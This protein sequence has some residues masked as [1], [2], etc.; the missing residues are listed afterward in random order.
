[1]RVGKRTVLVDGV[2]GLIAQQL[3]AIG[4]KDLLLAISYSPYAEETIGAVQS[5]VAAG[6]KVLAISD[7]AVSP[8]AKVAT[9]VLQVRESEVR[10]F[11][12]LTTSICLAEALVIGFAFERERTGARGR[13]RVA[14]TQ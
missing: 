6:A 8:I 14:K 2:G 3:G 13:K 1:L 9:Q 5:A 4:P 10:S 12:S 7:S 11:R